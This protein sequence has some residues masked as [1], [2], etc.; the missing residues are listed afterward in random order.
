VTVAVQILLV[1]LLRMA[2][3]N[4]H[5][6]VGHSSGEIAA[7]YAAGILSQA[8]AIRIGYYRGFHTHL[9]V[10]PDSRK[11]GMIAV[12]T[13]IEDACDFCELD[14][15]QGRLAVAA[16]NSATSVTI[17]SDIDAIEE[18]ET[19]LEE[20]GKFVWRL[21]VDKAYHSHHMRAAL[22]PLLRSLEACKIQVMRRPAGSPTWF[23]SIYKGVVIDSDDCLR[24]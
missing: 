20:E 6:V 23:S 15:F 17:S 21:G 22:E 12:G 16:S 11:G 18:A 2:G 8:D 4:F 9:A 14:G 13:S 1:N 10:G 5:A 7:A 24:G 19:V 3:V